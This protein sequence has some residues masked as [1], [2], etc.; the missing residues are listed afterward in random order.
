[1]YYYFVIH[2]D[3]YSSNCSGEHHQSSHCKKGDCLQHCGSFQ[4]DGNDL[5]TILF[6]DE[7]SELLILCQEL[8]C[9]VP[10]WAFMFPALVSI[11]F[12][13]SGWA[14]FLPLAI[15]VLPLLALCITFSPSLHFSF[16]VDYWVN[17]SFW[18]FWLCR[19]NNTIG[20]RIPFHKD[21]F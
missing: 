16:V 4:E 15:L 7:H 18:S 8:V 13:F 14:L 20:L 3:R 12:V 17:I 9:A 1:M 21:D 10:T 6:A 2:K 19:S 5:F 11:S